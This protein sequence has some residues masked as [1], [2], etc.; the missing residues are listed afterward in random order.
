M[1]ETGLARVLG[2][3]IFAHMPVKGELGIVLAA[4][5]MAV[6]VSEIT[7]NTASASLVVPVVLALAT[8]AGIDPVKPAIAATVGCSF[9][10]M[11]PVSTPPN[12]LVYATGRLRIRDM[13]RSGIWLDL[14]G[15]VIVAVWVTFVG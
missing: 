3:L 8:S 13:V 2:E 12:A 1:F 4:T 6:L 15:I 11:L 10:F 9:G 14:A 7:S 5:L